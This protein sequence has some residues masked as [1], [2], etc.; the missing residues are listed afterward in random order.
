MTEAEWLTPGDLS[1]HVKF[2][3]AQ[4]RTR[5]LR[6]F[7][8]GCC[9]PLEPWMYD[10]VM[11]EALLCAERLADGNLSDSTMVKWR[12]KVQRAEDARKPATNEQDATRQR[13]VYW[14]VR[15]VCHD[16]RFSCYA[17]SWTTLVRDRE[18][19]GEEFVRRGT[20]FAH[21]TLLEVFGNPFRRLTFPQE[22]LTSTVVALASQMYKS[23]DF[24]PMPI[25]ADALQDVGC[26]NDDILT[27]CRG[28]GPHVR[29]CW[30]VDLVLGKE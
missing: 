8:V 14:T 27:H 11:Q 9:R 15:S 20:A 12:Q 2:L 29:G 4:K 5:K 23:R 18:V 3:W 30:V 13:T 21:A 6:L 25:L 28:S 22:W 1:E 26:D 19:F 16:N 24:S 7:G 17:D 10:P